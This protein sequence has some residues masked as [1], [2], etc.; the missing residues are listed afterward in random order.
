MQRFANISA[1]LFAPLSDLKSLRAALQDK[2]KAWGLKGTILLSTEGINLFVAGETDNVHAL[3][4]TLRAIPGL[5]GLTPKLSESDH[6]PFNRM[7]IRIKKEIIAFGIEG[8]DPAQRPAPR[9]SP[10]DLKAWLDEGREVLL[11]DTRNDYEI[12]LGTF[13]GAHAIGVKHFREFPAAVEALPPEW[14]D[15]PVVTFCTGGIRCEKAAPFLESRG[16]RNIFQL[17]GGILNYFSEVGSEHYDGDCF[18]FDQRVGVDP[19][20]AESRFGQ[21]F[22]CLTP[23]TETELESPQY[24]VGVSC[25]YCFLSSEAQM[26]ASIEK[27]HAAIAAISNPL[28]G[29]EP[30]ENRRPFRVPAKWDGLTVLQCACAIVKHIGEDAWRA[31]F[32]SRRVLTAEGHPADP[33]AIVKAGERY[34]HL[35]P[36]LAEPAVSAAIRILHEDEALLVIEKPA[37]LPVHA[38]GRYSRNTLQFFLNKAYAPQHPHPAHRLDANTTGLILVA[39]TRHFAGLLQPQFSRGEVCKEYRALV[40]GHPLT[41]IFRCELPISETTA[42][43]G[44][45]QHDEKGLPSLTEFQVLSRNTDGTALLLAR[46]LTGRTNQIRVHLWE[47]GFPIVGDQLYLP[48]RKLGTVQTGELTDR[49]LCLHSS[50]LEFTHPLTQQRVRFDSSVDFT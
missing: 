17:D 33:N 14:K 32:E 7:L 40:H 9:I 21:C 39:R 44:A 5:A 29:S 20:L 13:R 22:A 34:F 47:M 41:D 50:H 38:G 15:K 27:K 49:R 12:K 10:R 3:L 18:V 25:P 23:L 19:S 28:P 24:Q 8:I 26:H 16:Y 1:Y 30:R 11:L 45:R 2:C 31:E 36:S 48:Q 42:D 6:Q 46:P 43:V 37:P 4:E 35:Y